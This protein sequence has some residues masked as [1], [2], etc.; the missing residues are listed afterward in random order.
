MANH[1]LGMGGPVA[2]LKELLTKNY[3]SMRR[4]LASAR[5]C[6]KDTASVV[7]LWSAPSSTL[8]RVAPPVDATQLRHAFVP[9]PRV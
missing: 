4:G 5:G 3:S 9:S 8:D 1:W 2:F 7:N 6:V